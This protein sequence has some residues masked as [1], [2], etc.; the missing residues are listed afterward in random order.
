[1]GTNVTYTITITKVYLNGVE[2][3]GRRLN[4]TSS[5]TA[6]VRVDW[7]LTT[8]KS[9]ATETSLRALQQSLTGITAFKAALQQALSNAGLDV[10]VTSVKAATTSGLSSGTTSKCAEWNIRASFV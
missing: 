8:T 3:Q 6:T 5:D 10:T 9:D 2:V 7:E 1:M 4:S